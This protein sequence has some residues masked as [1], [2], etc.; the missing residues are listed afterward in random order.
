MVFFC[1]RSATVV[2]TLGTREKVCG[3]GVAFVGSIV[4]GREK[5]WRTGAGTDGAILESRSTK[6]N[7]GSFKYTRLVRRE[8]MRG[9]G[10]D[11]VKYLPPSK[12]HSD[13]DTSVTN[14]TTLLISIEV[15]S[16]KAY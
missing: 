4:S 2:F 1:R 9:A 8:K 10:G 5:K 16:T 6:P 3:A 13:F 14:F 15:T 11:L 7:P 12:L